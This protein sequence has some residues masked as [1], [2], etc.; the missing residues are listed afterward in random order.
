MVH[1]QRTKFFV[2][3]IMIITI[4]L[5]REVSGPPIESRRG[6]TV[7]SEGQVFAFN[8]GVF[9]KPLGALKSQ[10]LVVQS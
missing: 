2:V 4:R 7:S 9:S 8:N 5:Q 6:S 1:L 10:K 3:I